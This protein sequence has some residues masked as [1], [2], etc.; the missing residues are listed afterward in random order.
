MMIASTK[1][2][3]MRQMRQ[4]FQ[5]PILCEIACTDLSE[6]ERDC[7]EEKFDRQGGQWIF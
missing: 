1:S 3:F 5:I 6:I 2:E 7:L 4:V